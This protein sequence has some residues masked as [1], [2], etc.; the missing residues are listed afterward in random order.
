MHSTARHSDLR[1]MPELYFQRT[2]AEEQQRHSLRLG[3]VY[4]GGEPFMGAVQGADGGWNVEIVMKDW[5]EPGLLDR[6]FE[7]ILRC[8][9]IPDGIQVRQ[10]RI[11]TGAR[12][13]VVNLLGRWPRAGAGRRRCSLQPWA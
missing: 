4:S 2:N 5:E 6:I 10:A 3:E 11:F 1:D 13:Q 7:A 12:G 9:H 8:I